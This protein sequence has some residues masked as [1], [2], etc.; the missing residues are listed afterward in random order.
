MKIAQ[1]RV[2]KDLMMG[3]DF[4]KSS[5]DVYFL[6]GITKPLAMVY[7]SIMLDWILVGECDPSLTVLTLDD[8]IVALISRFIHSERN[9]GVT[10]DPRDAPLDTS[11]Q[12][13]K[14]FGGIEN[15]N[16]GKVC[17]KADWLM[18]KIGM[19]I[20]KLSNESFQSYYDLRL[21]QVKL[22]NLN[23]EISSRFWFYPIISRVNVI[24]DVVL[25]EKFQMGV[26]T[27]VLSAKIDGISI[28]ELDDFNHYPSEGFAKSFTENYDVIAKEMEVIETLRGLTRLAALAKGMT[29]VDTQP[30]VDYWLR[31]YPVEKIV[32]KDTVNIL[33][34]NNEEFGF[35]IS[36]GVDLESIIMRINEGDASAFQEIVVCAR[37]DENQELLVWDFDIETADGQVTGIY[38]PNRIGNHNQITSLWTQALFLLEKKYY[39]NAIILYNDIIQ[40]IPENI[41]SYNNRGIAKSELGYYTEAIQ[42]FNIAIELDSEYVSAYYNRGKVKAKIGDYKQATLDFDK[43]IELYPRSTSERKIEVINKSDIEDYRNSIQY[44]EDAMDIETTLI[45]ARN[46]NPY[47]QLLIGLCYASGDTVFQKDF[48]LAEQWLITSAEQEFPPALYNLIALYDN[49]GNTL[50]NE[51]RLKWTR[52]AAKNGMKEAQYKLGAIYARGK[53]LEKNFEE[54][55]KLYKLSAEQGYAFAQHQ[56]ALHYYSGEGVSQDYKKSSYWYRKA[57]EQG[58]AASQV[59]LAFMYIDGYGVEYDP[60]EA[61]RWFRLAAKQGDAQGQ[62]NLGYSYYTGYG[63]PKNISTAK[64]LWQKAAKQGHKQAAHNLK[65]LQN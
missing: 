63:V 14:Y 21:E 3:K 10:I 35:K 23:T 6:G 13:I 52:V 34:N 18:K 7:D 49:A 64:E 20:Q 24:N 5:P 2:E 46:G 37:K 32:T 55:T 26:F 65:K 41:V 36:G 44:Y 56:L 27:E 45:K 61:V 8:W 42:D 17:F 39:Q 19:G 25:L 9:P 57:A 51:N 62:Y 22:S 1:E 60:E 40:L 58:N 4:R 53:F 31:D 38:F 16:F 50:K 48:Q 43:A 54:A 59:D 12:D 29:Q 30:L 28:D 15:T 11:N 33:R 47:A